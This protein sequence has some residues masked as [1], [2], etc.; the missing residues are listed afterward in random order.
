MKRLFLG[1]AGALLMFGCTPSVSDDTDD[2]NVPIA[3]FV[4]T[5]GDDA[6]DG[7]TPANAVLT[8][9]DA[10]LLAT[11]YGY[12][13]VCVAA[14]TYTQ[15]A[16]L[17]NDAVGNN[18]AGI[19]IVS[20][21]DINLLGG[22][23][24][25]FTARTG[26]SE[27]DGSGASTSKHIIWVQNTSNLTINGFVLCNAIAN[28]ST[29]HRDGGGVYFTNTSH[30]SIANCVISNN[31]ATNGGGIYLYNCSDNVI[32]GIIENNTSAYNGGGIYLIS[33]SNN[34]INGVIHNNSAAYRGGGVIVSGKGYNIFGGSILSNTAGT[35]YI[36]GGVCI[37]VNASNN[38]F[39]STCVIKW[40]IVIGGSAGD[41]G[42]VN[43]GD[44]D[45]S[46]ITNAGFVCSDNSPDD[47]AGGTPS[48]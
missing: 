33:S 21:D 36:G 8:I 44:G 9:Q 17:S 15:G 46:Q 12:D 25:D 34:T 24:S 27:L 43:N 45:G 5:T 2:T 6:N 31:F 47:W 32:D 13:T 30:S 42:G 28:G 39:T 14:G 41:G 29:P 35:G 3:V 4:S 38:V 22:Y 26:Y 1:I 20:I 37:Y 10:I 40:N 18:N 19:S 23:N 7:K 48:P 16:G 11:N